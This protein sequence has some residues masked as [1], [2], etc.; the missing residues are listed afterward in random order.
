MT[1]V[2]IERASRDPRR[3]LLLATRISLVVGVLGF[4]A[5]LVAGRPLL[6]VLALAGVGVGVVNNHL[7]DRSVGLAAPFLATA[8]FRILGMT[9]LVMIVFVLLHSAAAIALA[10]GLAAAQLSLS[11][12]ALREASR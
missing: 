7:T 11:A 6:A 12:A 2:A 10:G 8:G 5:L 1:S 3:A 9:V 4:A